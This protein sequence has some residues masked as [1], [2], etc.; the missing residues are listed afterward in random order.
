MRM[1]ADQDELSGP[2]RYFNKKFLFTMQQNRI[3]PLG[4]GQ[5]V[6]KE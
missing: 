2:C 5:V 4:W 6:E 1:S 3:N